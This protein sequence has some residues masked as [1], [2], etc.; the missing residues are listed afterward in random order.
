MSQRHPGTMPTATMTSAPKKKRDFFNG[1]QGLDLRDFR[2]PEPQEAREEGMVLGDAFLGRR[3]SDSYS[4]I[5]PI[6]Q[7]VGGHPSAEYSFPTTFPARQS[8]PG[9]CGQK[10]IVPGFSGYPSRGLNSDDSP[11]IVEAPAPYASSSAA[12]HP[13]WTGPVQASPPGDGDGEGDDGKKKGRKRK[14]RC[15]MCANHGIYVEI[16]GHKWYCPYKNPEHNCP[17]CEIT[18]KKQYFMAEQQKLT[19][20]QQQQQHR[21][22]QGGTEGGA[23]GEGCHQGP[24]PVTPPN[25]PSDFPRM[26]ELLEETDHI[27]DEDLFRKI[28]EHVRPK[29]T[30]H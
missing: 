23:V 16:K 21:H 28:N 5:S 15:R 10:V 18:R 8:P 6:S 11:P 9:Y 17:K 25:K 13:P 3:P 27:L 1:S 26:K 14:Q 19:R 7:E 20:E 22:L 4:P 12:E 30:H 24:M 29:V 2:S